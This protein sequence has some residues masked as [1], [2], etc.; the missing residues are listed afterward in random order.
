MK[1]IYIYIYICGVYFVP[2]SCCA[3]SISGRASRVPPISSIFVS[4]AG[5]IYLLEEIRVKFDTSIK[6][7]IGEKYLV[8][9]I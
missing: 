1:I 5:E 7:Y 9:M 6:I 3:L 8:E 2:L 4:K